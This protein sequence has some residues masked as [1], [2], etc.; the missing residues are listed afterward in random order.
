M[1]G[2]GVIHNPSMRNEAFSGALV[3]VPT[4][5]IQYGFWNELAYEIT[6][7]TALTHPA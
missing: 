4:W 7:P 5:S 1:R 6:V 3:I 2:I